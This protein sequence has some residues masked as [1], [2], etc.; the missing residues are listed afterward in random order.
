MHTIPRTRVLVVCSEPVV[1]RGLVGFAEPHPDLD[2]VVGDLRDIV[3]S[4]RPFDIVLY[5]VMGL[6]RHESSELR[7]LVA[8]PG[9]CVLA[10]SRDLRPELTER[11]LRLGAHGTISLHV[12]GETMIR[13]IREVAQ[14][15][16][17]G[18]PVPRRVIMA[19]QPVR[20]PASAAAGT[21][22]RRER[23]VLEL[24]AAGYSNAEIS[25]QLYL[26]INSVKTF[27]RGAYR[28]IGV[29]SRT[30]AV[31]W[32]FAHGLGPTSNAVPALAPHA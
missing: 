17:D 1:A 32:A 19:T 24:I 26:S 10:L 16:V 22:S 11:A 13:T 12:S 25:A 28:R 8:Q 18:L 3:A 21:L 23:D 30:Q 2:V 7:A 27:I 15:K 14:R 6:L 31:V 20:S 9:A 29:T 5:D 4:P